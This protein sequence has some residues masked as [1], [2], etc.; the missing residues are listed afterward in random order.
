MCDRRVGMGFQLSMQ[1]NSY[2]IITW[3]CLDLVTWKVRTPKNVTI[4]FQSLWIIEG[5]GKR[6]LY[7]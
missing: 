2:V 7:V 6:H 1:C 3:S 4:T 5:Y